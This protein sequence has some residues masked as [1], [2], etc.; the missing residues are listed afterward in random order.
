MPSARTTTPPPRKTATRRGSD[1]V[2]SHRLDGRLGEKVSIYRDG[3]Q[4]PEPKLR[5]KNADGSYEQSLTLTTYSS[6]GGGGL[7][8]GG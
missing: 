7:F 5:I 2:F 4:P 1:Y 3:R 8:G 6:S